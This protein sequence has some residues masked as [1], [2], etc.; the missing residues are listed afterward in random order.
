MRRSI[1]WII[2]L[3]ACLPAI[4]WLSS[5]VDALEYLRLEKGWEWLLIVVVAIVYATV[6]SRIGDIAGAVLPHLLAGRSLT[7]DERQDFI[8]T[9]TDLRWDGVECDKP[10]DWRQPHSRLQDWAMRKAYGEIPE[11]LENKPE[12][13]MASSGGKQG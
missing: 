8:R 12:I 6:A 7:A 11:Y 5:F 1:S 13:I 2:L 10:E 3:V 4:F 9:L